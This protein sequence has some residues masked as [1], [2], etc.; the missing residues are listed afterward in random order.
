MLGRGLIANPALGLEYSKGCELDNG[1]KARLVQ[2]MHDAMLRE[3]TPRL[4]GNTQLLSKLKP[5]WEY[6]LPDMEKRDRKAIVK[7]STAEKY[8]M[9][10]NNAIAHY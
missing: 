7:A 5:Y 6:L 4:Q 2:Q 10:V 9:A 1:E 3:L 8:L